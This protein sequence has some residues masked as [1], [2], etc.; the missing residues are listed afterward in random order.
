MALATP[1]PVPRHVPR[2]HRRAL[3]VLLSTRRD[4]ALL[5]ARVVLG[6]VMLSH[7]AQKVFGLFG[8]GGLGA[9]M[10]SFEQHLGLPAVLAVLVMI[11]EFFGGLGLVA[12]F[13]SR[14]A[15]GG[16]ILVMTGAIAVVHARFGWFMNWTGTQ[17]GEGFE[18]HLLAIA[19][20]VVILLRGGGAYSVDRTLARRVR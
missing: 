10:S 7:G 9:T 1:L 12:G 14:I 6:V 15:A 8:G 20:A 16:I 18:Y 4:S 3:D 13:L 5:C 17:A 19:L 11:A 2:Y